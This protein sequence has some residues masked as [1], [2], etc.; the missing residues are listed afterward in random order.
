[1]GRDL[2]DDQQEPQTQHHDGVRRLLGHIHADDH[3]GRGTG[4]EKRP[5]L[6]V[7]RYVRQL[8]F[9]LGR[10]HLDPLQRAP[11]RTLL[12]VR[13][14]GPR[15]DQK[16]GAQRP[17]RRL[18]H[19]GQRIQIQPERQKR[20]LQPGRIQSRFSADQPAADP[21]RPV[22][23]RN[24]HGA[25]AQGMHPPSRSGWICFPAARTRSAARS[26]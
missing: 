13:E 19:L 1:M 25:A 9:L 17:Q 14:R 24:R 10:P 8:L 2:A 23:Q 5:F 22:F 26:A 21:V 12:A 18:G 6:T 16:T 7:G 3:A 20:R 4:I 15:C 11:F